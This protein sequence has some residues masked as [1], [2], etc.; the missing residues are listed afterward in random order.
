MPILLFQGNSASK[1]AAGVFSECL[2]L[3]LL[4][5]IFQNPVQSGIQVVG[6]AISALSDLVSNSQNPLYPDL[7]GLLSRGH[8]PSHFTIIQ[9]SNCIHDEI[10]LQDFHSLSSLHTEFHRMGWTGCGIGKVL[11]PP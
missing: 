9:T 2:T 4:Q 7:R 8:R 3:V 11:N 5:Q 1:N 10:N 6:D